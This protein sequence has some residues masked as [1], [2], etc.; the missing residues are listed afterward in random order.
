MN[1]IDYVLPAH[2]AP[3]LIN[4]DASGITD[5]EDNQISDWLESNPEIGSCLSCT[6]ESEFRNFHDA[7]GVWP[8]DCLTYTFPVL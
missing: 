6:E 8:C 3:C 4:R 2:W 7:P 5:E 1:T